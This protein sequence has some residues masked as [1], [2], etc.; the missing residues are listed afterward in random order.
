MMAIK[1]QAALEFLTTY[2]WAFLVILVAIGG[3]SYFGVFD[4][5]KYSP[6]RSY[7]KELPILNET[8]TYYPLDY[9]S[10]D[11]L[12]DS[13]VFGYPVVSYEYVKYYNSTFENGTFKTGGGGRNYLDDTIKDFYFNNCFEE[14]SS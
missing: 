2:G 8:T 12:H 11:Y 4:F 9:Y 3:L 6:D 14:V 1:G 7:G 13:L 5:S 10:C